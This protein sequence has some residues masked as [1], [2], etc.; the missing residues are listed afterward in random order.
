MSF[1]KI[2]ISDIELDHHEVS[3]VVKCIKNKMLSFR[4]KYVE[5][6][7]K[8][9]EKFIKSDNAI[10][11]SNGTTALELALATFGVKKNDE[12]LIPNFAFAAV[13]NSVINIGAVP[14]LVDIDKNSWNI[15]IAEIKKKITFKT[16][17]IIAVHNYG[18]FCDIAAIKKIIKNKKIFLIEDCAEALGTKYNKKYIGNL[19]DCSTFSFYA[20]KTITTGEGGMLIFKKKIYY[21]RALILRNQGRDI[22]D[23]FFKHKLRGFNFRLTNIQAAI[24]YAQL[25]KIKKLISKRK[26]IFNFYN[27][28]FIKFKNIKLIPQPKNTE[29][30]YWLYTLQI[31]NIDEKK[32]NSL[33]N[34]L[35]KKGIETRPGFYPISE[36]KP[37][38][39]FKK[40]G[41]Y[42]VS[43]KIS[44]QILSLPSSPKLSKKTINYITSI[45][46]IELKKL[47]IV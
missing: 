44:S 42:L 47:K 25:F 21:K 22:S 30:S 33:I 13:I 28:F 4:G 11:V 5:K 37:Y 10:S 1:K 14:V 29:N 45:F 34:S 24:G 46:L 35:K 3:L 15:D 18:I 2:S 7:E 6:F 31:L 9:F 19:S 38:K 40:N 39:K 20:N 8:K 43:K 12:V 16:K 26:K 23:E 36:M 32:R 27:K 17:A 41:K